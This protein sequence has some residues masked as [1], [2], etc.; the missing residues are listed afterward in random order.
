[1][2]AGGS[3]VIVASTPITEDAIPA[4]KRLARIA[5][6]LYLLMALLGGA[7]HLGVR[8]GI[9]VPGDAAATARNIVDHAELFR[10][11]LVADIAMATVFVFVGVTLYLL[12]REVH[13]QAAGALVL[14]VAVGVGMI[15]T[16]LVFHH[17]ALLVATEPAYGI[18]GT[19]SSD[20]LVLLLVDLHAT[21]YT[22]A[23]IFFGLW[24]LPLG[25]LTYR[26]RLLPRP[27]SVLLIVAGVSWII[28]TV[29]TFLLPDLPEVLHVAITA[30][31]VAE[32]WLIAYL[33]TKGVRT[34]SPDESTL[35]PADA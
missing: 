27:L 17:A 19:T 24:L 3:S 10:F 29:A 33:L 26:A 12:F 31:T 25:H 23:G 20:G 35:A 32:F 5:G 18:P 22:L 34:P 13:R 21:G 9:H 2:A 16:N 8:A 6:S 7:A 28:D 14:F 1:M 15:L 30:P 11:A 4:P